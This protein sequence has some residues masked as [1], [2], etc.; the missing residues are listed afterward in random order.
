MNIIER[1][2][3]VLDGSGIQEI[4]RF[5]DFPIKM[6]CSYI[7]ESLY[8]DMIWGISESGM[9]QLLYLLPLEMIYTPEYHG[10]GKVGKLW[11][12]HHRKFAD[13]IKQDKY[14]NILEIGGGSGALS[15]HFLY[16]DNPYSISVGQ[17][18]NHKFNYT[19]I[20]PSCNHTSNDSRLTF[21]NDYIENYDTNKKYDVIIHSHVFEHIYEPLTFLAKVNKLLSDDGYHY[22]SIPN[23]KLWLEYGCN[24]TLNFEHTFYVDLTLME[25]F[26]NITGFVVIEV[27]LR[28]HSIFIKSKKEFIVDVTKPDL[29]YIKPLFLNYIKQLQDDIAKINKTGYD[30]IYVF[31]GHIFTQLLINQGI[32]ESRIKCI[33]DNDVNKHG[34]YLYGTELKVFPPEIIKNENF[35]I[36]LLRTGL[37]DEEIKLQLLEYNSEVIF[38]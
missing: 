37:Y 1:N 38:V 10:S 14:N 8:M 33:L 35:P 18:K 11:Q 19:I 36:V 21:I 2:S 23:M 31:G 15:K 13:F 34:K 4:F 3:C 16:E 27:I 30:N 20:E 26:L 24:N 17:D 12:E 22:V 28:E 6:D 7:K 25:Y 5:K 29:S 9:L 32:D